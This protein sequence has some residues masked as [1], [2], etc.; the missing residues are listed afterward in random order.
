MGLC[1][2][3]VGPAVGVPQPKE[4]NSSQEMDDGRQ[5]ILVLGQQSPL[6]EGVVDLLQLVGYQVAVSSSWREVQ[7]TA[8]GTPPSLIVV[9]LSD[10][11]LDAVVVSEAVGTLPKWSSVPLLYIG[12]AGDERVRDLQ[13]G[14]QYQENGQVHVYTHTLLSVDGLLEKVHTC[15]A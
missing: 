9:D 15:L 1:Q 5:K 11:T 12:F 3:V 10:A 14:H 13:L 4:G 8:G 6:L 2:R 7:H